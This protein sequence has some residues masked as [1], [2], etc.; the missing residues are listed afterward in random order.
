MNVVI[1]KIGI[2]VTNSDGVGSTQPTNTDSD[3]ATCYYRQI[4]KEEDKAVSWLTKLGQSLA[5]WLRENGEY[6]INKSQEVL[7]DFPEGYFLYEYLDVSSDGKRTSNIYLFGAHKFESPSQ[8]IP[9]LKWLVSKDSQQCQCAHCP[10]PPKVIKSSSSV[11]TS[12]PKV[13][14]S[15]KSSSKTTTKSSKVSSESKQNPSESADSLQ[16]SRSLAKSRMLKPSGDGESSKDSSTKEHKKDDRPKAKYAEYRTGEIVWVILAK[17]GDNILIDKFKDLSVGD[18]PITNWP[19]VI[20]SRGKIAPDVDI[21]KFTVKLVVLNTEVSIRRTG[22]IP[23]KAFNPVIPEEVLKN[24]IGSNSNEQLEPEIDTNIQNYVRAVHRA[25]EAAQT[26][27]PMKMFKYVEN[28][29]RLKT[30]QDP[31]ERQ[32]LID[33]EKYPHYEAFMYGAEMIRPGDLVR[34]VPENSMDLDTEP[35][36]PEFLEIRTIYRHPEKGMQFTGNI[37]QRG[38]L[39]NKTGPVKLE[40]YKW[41]ISHDIGEEYTIDLEDIAGRFY[42]MMPHLTARTSARVFKKLNDRM[43]IIESGSELEK[44]QDASS[45]IVSPKRSMAKLSTRIDNSDE[46]ASPPKR[47][48]KYIVKIPKKNSVKKTKKNKELTSS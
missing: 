39:L 29:S 20:Y 3:N 34:L 13:S 27:S 42:L 17:T 2:S 40:D 11:S 21:V 33:M 8:F 46:S 16:T 43:E 25:N 48:K 4:D 6:K 35:E 32:R 45:N 36:Y 31:G 38:E 37:L 47:Q 5:K 24:V 41:W 10:P 14:R 15:S 7:L 44:S 30:V 18:S 22:L 1:T 23:W 28:N 9:H 26:Y 12:K 19:G